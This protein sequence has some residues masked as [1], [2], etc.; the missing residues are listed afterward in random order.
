MPIFTVFG[1]LPAFLALFLILNRIVFQLK[2]YLLATVAFTLGIYVSPYWDR[3]TPIH[4]SVA[5][6][7]AFFNL[8]LNLP[9]LQLSYTYRYIF[10]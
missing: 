8:F 9:S 2:R 1:T 10:E 5:L 7:M 6:F 4:F 3:I